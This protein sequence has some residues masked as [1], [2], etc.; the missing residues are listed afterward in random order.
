M[1]QSTQDLAYIL[2]ELAERFP[3]KESALAWLNSPFNEKAKV[4]RRDLMI[5]GDFHLVRN[6]LENA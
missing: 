5:R 1:N 2:V 3:N 6:Q 4:T